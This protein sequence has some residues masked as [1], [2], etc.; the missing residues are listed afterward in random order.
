[1]SVSNSLEMYGWQV[2][3]NAELNSTVFSAKHK[4][5][6]FIQHVFLAGREEPKYITRNVGGFFLAS[7]NVLIP[8]APKGS[9][10]IPQMIS[11]KKREMIPAKAPFDVDFTEKELNF[12]IDSIRKYLDE[13]MHP[14]FK[15]N[16]KL[17]AAVVWLNSMTYED[18]MFDFI[19]NVNTD[20]GGL[21]ILKYM[22][23]LQSK[24][25]A[26][27]PVFKE[28]LNFMTV[29]SSYASRILM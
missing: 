27:V 26:M 3:T 6:S 8:E 14:D 17:Y 21:N 2:K 9:W 5:T 22:A 20:T 15:N 24:S 19:T 25:Q 28:A 10:I 23:A 12:T 18:E 7:N 29:P 16:I 13:H 1:M 11:L 4:Q